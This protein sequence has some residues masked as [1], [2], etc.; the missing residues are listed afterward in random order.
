MFRHSQYTTYKIVT[1]ILIGILGYAGFR[2]I[3]PGYAFVN[4][5]EGA[6]PPN[7]TAEPV[8]ESL[9][10]SENVHPEEASRTDLP[11]TQFPQKQEID[12]IAIELRDVRRE[13]DF[14]RVEI[15]Y[16]LPSDADWLPGNSADDVILTVGNK[17]IPLWGGGFI[18][19]NTA[20]NG[21]EKQRCEYLLFPMTGDLD[22]SYFSITIKRLV[23]SMPEQPNCIAVQEKLTQAETG[24][25]IQC[26]HKENAFDYT[27]DQKPGSMS[28]EEAR[29]LIYDAFS[30]IV[31]GPW[32]FTGN[33]K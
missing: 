33:L 17:T 21:T 9:R 12:D 3:Q 26:D 6:P 29:Q 28:A 19:W 27:I 1:L 14:V 7:A 15:C 5:V 23:T 32:V 24:I 25:R 8:T 31:E 16:D 11:G 20:P 4:Q 10:S 30:E 22:L 2:S 18:R 13:K